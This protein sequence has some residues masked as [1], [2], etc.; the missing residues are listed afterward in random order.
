MT[1][2]IPTPKNATQP[3]VITPHNNYPTP[4]YISNDE[5]KDKD[6]KHTPNL[7]LPPDE[8]DQISEPWY[9][10]RPRYSVACAVLNQQTGALEEYPALMRG[11]NRKVWHNTYRNDLCRLVQGMPDCSDGTNTIFFIPQSAVPAGR[12]ITYEKK[13][14]SI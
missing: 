4:N 12:K 7:A 10:L 8:V 11:P 3:R 2:N 5:D 6:D 14:C 1:F 9:N 13:E